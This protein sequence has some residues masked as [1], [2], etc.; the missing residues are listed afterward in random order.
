MSTKE[1]KKLVQDLIKDWN[2]LN[3]DE[4]KLRALCDKYLA[5]SYVRHSSSGDLDREKQIQTFMSLISAIPYNITID[6]LVAE[7]DKVVMR[8]TGKGTHKGTFMGVP[9]S[10]KKVVQT[11][12]MI[13]KIAGGKIVEEWEQFD[14]MSFMTQLGAIP[15]PKK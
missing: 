12:I 4:A 9:P 5:P 7:D 8:Y 14:T 15:A 1:D 11:A 2:A 3:G 13:S 10:G 6:D